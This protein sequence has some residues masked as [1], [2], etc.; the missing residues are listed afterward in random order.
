M[1]HTHITSLIGA[2]ALLLPGAAAL[3]SC[4]QELCYDHF[5]MASLRLSWEQEWERDYGKNHSANWN[6]DFYGHEY[7]HLRPE[8]P[9]WVNIV[10]YTQD[11]N[12]VESFLEVDGGNIMING[13]ENKSF[14]L[15]N[16]DTEF[17]VLSDMASHASA[18]AS[19]TSRARSSL[20]TFSDIY[21]T[22]RS[23]NPPDMLYAAY[24]DQVPYVELHEAKD[25]PIKMQPLVYTYIIRYEFEYGLEKVALARGAL[26]GMAE[27]VYLR[28]GATSDES[29]IVLYDC[30]L[31]NYGCVAHVKTFGIPGFP[32]Q[33]YGRQSSS[34]AERPYTVN[35]EVRL[36]N[37]KT[38]E[39]DYDI[40]DQIASQPRGG[41]IHVTGIRVEDE[42]SG[43]DPASGSAFDVEVEGWGEF[44]DIDLPVIANPT[45]DKQINK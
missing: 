24:I 19:S 21:P 17:I 38:L 23:T 28:T 44:E 3:T 31:T 42:V 2:L 35:L 7:D 8:I 5:R 30:E 15:Y 6:S 43:N 10:T 45:D 29:S 27:S 18:R 12:P 25:M 39:F 22:V 9:E 41:V 37:G 11:A 40:A 16:G 26:G 4:R 20:T 36:T 13:D 14:L 32:D 1:K 34:R 33:Y